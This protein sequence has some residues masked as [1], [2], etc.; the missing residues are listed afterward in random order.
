MKGDMDLCRRIRLD[1]EANPEATEANTISLHIDD[2]DP[3][4]RE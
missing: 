4:E 2:R 3:V 1:V